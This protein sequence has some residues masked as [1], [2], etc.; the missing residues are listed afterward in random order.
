MLQSLFTHQQHFSH[1]TLPAARL[2]LAVPR[3][4]LYCTV[5]TA[6]CRRQHNACGKQVGVAAVAQTSWQSYATH[7]SQRYSMY[8]ILN[9]GRGTWRGR[10]SR[11]SL[12]ITAAGGWCRCSRDH[13]TPFKSIDDRGRGPACR[14]AGQFIAPSHQSTAGRS[15]MEWT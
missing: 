9:S 4:P 3:L 13:R 11:R 8:S 12:E 2:T 7:R 14:L 5:Y 15:C 6:V 10:E 1:S